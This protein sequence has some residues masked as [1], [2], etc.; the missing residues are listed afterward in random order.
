MENK[1][2]GASELS[3]INIERLNKIKQYAL[4]EYQTYMNPSINLPL[5]FTK[6]TKTASAH[7]IAG[8]KPAVPNIKPHV[9]I[10]PLEKYLLDKSSSKRFQLNNDV[11]KCFFICS[12]VFL[13]DEKFLNILKQYDYLN[14][15]DEFIR[16][17]IDIDE[18]YQGNEKRANMHKSMQYAKFI[19]SNNDKLIKLMAYFYKFH[20]ISKISIIINKLLQICYFNPELYNS[21]VE[22][23]EDIKTN[24]KTNKIG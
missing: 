9:N 13:D 2:F 10:L 17:Y 12:G 7:K 5:S 21:Y 18:K 4:Y 16:V 6:V 8:N 24:Q 1:L 22:T 14:V 23:D 20:K 15:F 3:T 19:K 11:E